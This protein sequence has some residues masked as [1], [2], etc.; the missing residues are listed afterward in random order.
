MLP[1]LFPAAYFHILI[2]FF[3]NN[4]FEIEN[5]F[6]AGFMVNGMQFIRFRYVESLEYGLSGRYY[7]SC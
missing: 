6:M 3:L 1:E 7:V 4:K 2:T 5:L